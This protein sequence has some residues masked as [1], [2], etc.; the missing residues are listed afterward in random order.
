[1]GMSDHPLQLSGFNTSS[2]NFFG[3][4]V[5]SSSSSVNQSNSNPNDNHLM[6][7]TSGSDS[8]IRSTMTHQHSNNPSMPSNFTFLN[9]INSIQTPQNQH[10]THPSHDIPAL[11]TPNPQQLEQLLEVNKQ[12]ATMFI[13]F[14]TFGT[15][16]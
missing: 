3:S 4:S 5:S 13:N 2:Q 6:E 12:Q 9:E 14:T 15:L 1:M 7:F 10:Q 11:I 16:F 8:I